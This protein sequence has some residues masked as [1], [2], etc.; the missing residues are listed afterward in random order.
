MEFMMLKL[1]KTA[2]V[3]SL[4]AFSMTAALGEM[5]YAQSSSQFDTARSNAQFSNSDRRSRDNGDQVLGGVVG[6]LAGG[7]IGSQVAGRGSRTEGALIGGLLGGVTGAAIAGTDS[8]SRRNTGFNRG[9]NRN[10]RFNRGF[11]SRRSYDYN[12][13]YDSVYG[14][15]NRRSFSR[16]FGHPRS[17][18]GF[19]GRSGISI[20]F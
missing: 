20:G 13:G 6:A 2:A 14:Y 8:R 7:V 18:R 10:T 19:R 5:A 4:A 11:V 3:T 15:N 16:G 12:R 17:S 1:L 9:F